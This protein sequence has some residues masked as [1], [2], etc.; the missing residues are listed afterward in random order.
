V[1]FAVLALLDVSDS[2]WLWDWQVARF[3]EPRWPSAESSPTAVVFYSAIP[4]DARARLDHALAL[5][6][7]RAV[8]RILIVGGYR[9]DRGY[10]GTAELAARARLY[11][12]AVAHDAG[13][14][15]TLSNLEAICPLR[16]VAAP[17]SS[18]VLVS[19]PVHILRIWAQRWRINCV[20]DRFLG[21]DTV[22]PAG[23][24]VWKWYLAQRH[25]L[26]EAARLLLGE[27]LYREALHHWRRRQNS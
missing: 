7:R 12:R 22:A 15:D 25:W 13:S 21:Y 19:D 17:G 11:T 9:D 23:G 2:V 5:L 4:E 24:P 18:L 20:D 1:G 10:N 26:A 14:Y 6:G 3:E 27:E 16:A 8:D